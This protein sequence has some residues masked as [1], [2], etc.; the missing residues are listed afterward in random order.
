MQ[1]ICSEAGESALA[2]STGTGW[3]ECLAKDLTGAKIHLWVDPKKRAWCSLQGQ[4]F[5]RFS[6]METGTSAEISHCTALVLQAHVGVLPAAWSQEWKAP[7][8]AAG[9][10]A[11]C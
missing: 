11:R 2:A 3:T 10:E 9:D 8:A 1:A 5:Y 4:H 6:G 7:A